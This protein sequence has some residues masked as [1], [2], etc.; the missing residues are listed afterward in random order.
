MRSLANDE[1]RLLKG[2][3]IG[4]NGRRFQYGGSEC[5]MYSLYFI[6]CM[7]HG[8]TFRKFVKHPVPDKDMISLR[9][10]LFADQCESFN[11]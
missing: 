1:P 8:M 11:R 7:I 9:D 5:G 2:R 3:R 10:V 6:I 4:F